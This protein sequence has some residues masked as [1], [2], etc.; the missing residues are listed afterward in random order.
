MSDEVKVEQTPIQLQYS[1]TDP[2]FRTVVNFRI[3]DP[4]QGCESQ[5]LMDW[6]SVM[7]VIAVQID[8]ARKTRIIEAYAMRWSIPTVEVAHIDP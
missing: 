2:A 7:A 8:T 6:G 3:H 1:G 4:P 5:Q